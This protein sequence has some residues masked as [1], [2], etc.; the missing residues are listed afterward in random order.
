MLRALPQARERRQKDIYLVKLLTAHWSSG[1]PSI[2]ALVDL[3]KDY[4]SADRLWRQCLERHPDLRG[5][6]YND[7]VKYEQKAQIGLEYEVNYHKDIKVGDNSL[8]LTHNK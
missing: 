5:L 4:A 2:N 3:V 7:K 1:N 6:D 8:D